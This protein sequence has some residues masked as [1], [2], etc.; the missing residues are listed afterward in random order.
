MTGGVFAPV[1]EAERRFEP[2]PLR[3]DIFAPET[4]GPGLETD[5]PPAWAVETR[6]VPDEVSVP[7]Q[8]ESENPPA[9]Y[10]AMPLG[11]DLSDHQGT[12][13]PKHPVALP[14]ARF[15]EL[16]HLGK[17]FAIVKASQYAAETTFRDHYDHVREAGLVRGSY[18]FF[19]ERPVAEQVRLLLG[20]VGRLGPGELAPSLDVEDESKRLWNAYH[21]TYDGTGTVAGSTAL[22][23]ALQAWLDAVEAALG[24]TP[25]LY[26]GVVWRDGLQS[27][28]MS[29]YPLWTLPNRF[30]FGGWARADIWQYAED[31]EPK[32]H[33]YHETG[34]HIGGIDFDAYNG[35]IWGVRGLADLGRIG[36][37]TSPAGTVLAYSG[38]DRHVHLVLGTNDVD[39]MAGELPGV[40]G[41]PVLRL[42]GDTTRLYFR[43]DGRVV[44]ASRSGTS[45][46]WDVDDLSSVAGIRALH[47]PSAVTTADQRAVVFWGEDDDWHLCT[48][49]NTGPWSVTAVLAAAR[50][51][52]GRTVPP[53]SGQPVAYRD[54]ASG[55][56]RVFG[57]A[58]LLGHL[59]EASLGRQGW[60]TTDVTATAS[61]PHGIPPAATYSPAVYA[62]G[63]ATLIVYRAIR[64][65]LWQINRTTGQATDLTAAAVGSV[66]AAGH[67]CCFVLRGEPHVVYRGVDRNL[68]ELTLRGGSWRAATLSCDVPVASDPTCTPDGTVAVRATDGTV[69][70][71]TLVGQSWTCT[72]AARPSSQGHPVAE[73]TSPPPHE[74]AD[75][76]A[77]RIFFAR[78]PE[79]GGRRLAPDEADLIREWRLIRAS[80]GSAAEAENGWDRESA[81]GG[82]SW[83]RAMTRSGDAWGTATES[84]DPGL[85]IGDIG[86]T[87][88]DVVGAATDVAAKVAAKPF[89][90]FVQLVD[91]LEKLAINDGYSL[92]QRVTAFRKI[93]YDSTASGTAYPG[94]PSG[95]VWNI[96]IPGAVSTSLPPSWRAVAAAKISALAAAKVLPIDLVSVDVGHVL[97]G[98]DARDH[99]TTISL[100]VLGFPLVR[101]RSNLEAATFV[102][103]LGSLVVEYL[104]AS[105]RSF[106]D[107][108]ME[109]DPMLLD[110]TYAKFAPGSDLA[111]DA[112]AY[113]LPLDS[114]RS[115]AMNLSAYYRATAGG[116][117]RRWQGFANAIGLGVFTP[118][119]A[120][121]GSYWQ[122]KIV[123]TFSGSTEQWHNDVREQIFNAALA[124]AA[125]SRKRSDVVNVLA[126]PRPGV[127]IPTFWEMYWNASGWVLDEFLL[128]LKK[129]TNAEMGP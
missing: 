50:R 42:A 71:S 37:A 100:G 127:V 2:R 35:T 73:P 110:V 65:E 68:H 118:A 52:S 101:M 72:V 60:M 57:R 53:S 41:D 5:A 119:A 15:Q 108:A 67:P 38:P 47:E 22:L 84:E 112:D 75:A 66:L 99:P 79:R 74:N 95:G 115:F 93:Y 11:V 25:L 16:A 36:V 9:A 27:P 10:A 96:L 34:V 98:L 58:G 116:W 62:D 107:T 91:D 31:G 61:G 69:R 43:S 1:A 109:L 113:L 12:G 106:R 122:A 87:I 28:R 56:V 90:D 117:K 49:P 78:H 86:K 14:V 103:D 76:V 23:D 88:G 81:S 124:Y 114:S 55:A 102:G 92:V 32:T 6:T 59:I 17:V 89:D 3:S 21:Y 4:E 94:A 121:M 120:A 19:T 54:P 129:A 105:K 111:A 20:L 97:T 82:A 33:P 85:S 125:A 29:Q 39:L 70:M 83:L 26:T 45:G 80:V 8:G 44:E 48:R 123:G 128:R 63:A 30:P 51:E 18:H 126:E 7:A 77:D 104:G 13:P 24:R 40:G 46:S 64:G